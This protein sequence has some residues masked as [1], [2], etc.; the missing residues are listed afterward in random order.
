MF[1]YKNRNKFSYLQNSLISW[2]LYDSS[3]GILKKKTTVNYSTCLCFFPQ[4]SYLVHQKGILRSERSN[5]FST[6]N[7]FMCLPRVT[8]IIIDFSMAPNSIR[9]WLGKIETGRTSFLKNLEYSVSYKTTPIGFHV[10]T[11]TIS[12]G[13][14]HVLSSRT[15][16]TCFHV[17]QT[18]CI[19]WYFD[20]ITVAIQLVNIQFLQ[21][22][23]WTTYTY[24]TRYR[25]RN[26]IDQYYCC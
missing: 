24:W 23:H 16:T 1:H 26:Q 2:P 12:D 20:D 14:V 6:Y 7:C 3:F 13:L 21:P 19:M 17:N 8:W 22:E 11:W 10:L 18:N 15:F 9:Q 4:S 5:L 25:G